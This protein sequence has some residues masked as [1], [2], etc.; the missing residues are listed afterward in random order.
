MRAIS[1]FDLGDRLFQTCLFGSK[2]D[3][4]A[5][6]QA[7]RRLADDDL[8]STLRRAVGKRNRLDARKP[9]DRRVMAEQAFARQAVGVDD[10]QRRSR[11]RRH[12]H[13]RAHRANARDEIDQP[14]DLV[15]CGIVGIGRRRPFG[16]ADQTCRARCPRL[17]YAPTALPS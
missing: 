3:Q 16:M 9:L 4:A 1:C 6:R 8:R 15:G 17:P 7:D 5:E 10:D 11:S 12:V 13:F 14:V 2:I